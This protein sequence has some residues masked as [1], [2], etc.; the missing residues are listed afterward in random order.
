MDRRNLTFYDLLFGIIILI[1][2]G[3]R[4]VFSSQWHLSE[5]EASLVLSAASEPNTIYQLWTNFLFT[6]FKSSEFFAR[7]LPILFGTFLV[8]MPLFLRKNFGNGVTLILMI[9]LAIDP[10][11][12][13]LSKQAGPEILAITAFLALLIFL[14]EKKW[15]L[16]GIFLSIGLLSGYQF[17]IGAIT[18]FLCTAFALLFKPKSEEMIVSDEVVQYLKSMFSGINWKELFTSSGITL[19]IGGTLFFSKP[20][21]LTGIASGITDFFVREN[22]GLYSISISSLLIGLIVSYGSLFVV[23]LLGSWKISPS[24]R[25]FIWR[26]VFIVFILVSVFPDHQLADYIWMILPLYYPAAKYLSGLILKSEEN[27][28]LVFGGAFALSMLLVFSSYSLMEYISLASDSMADKESL[29][30]LLSSIV[31]FVVFILVI[32]IVGWGWSVDVSRD[33]FLYIFVGGIILFAIL[34]SMR[35]VGFSTVPQELMWIRTGYFADADLF[36]KTIIELE[37]NRSGKN[38]A[39]ENSITGN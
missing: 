4:V 12:I 19:L 16:A 8:G 15:I 25:R 28:F 13:A 37:Q 36:D 22:P 9:G 35:S 39:I 27:Q 38:G 23:S 34:P 1:A 10:G 29:R 31:A 30:Y 2:F 7:L 5:K 6:F 21:A 24:W 32:I 11:L 18:F 20:E 33:L 3:L 17:W 14:Y 26:W